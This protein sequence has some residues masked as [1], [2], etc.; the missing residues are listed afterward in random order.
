[1]RKLLLLVLL[2]AAV[3]F[4]LYTHSAA[5]EIRRTFGEVERLVSRA[6]TE[7]VMENAVKSRM[8]STYVIEGCVFGLK[9][10]GV[11]GRTSREGFSGGVLAFRNEVKRIRLRFIDL[12]IE[13][14]DRM[15]HV[16]GKADFTGTDTNGRLVEP[17]IRAFSAD[18]RREDDGR[19]RFMCVR[20]D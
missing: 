4:W 18:L 19:W 1:M 3:A 10:F 9:E 20:M 12:Q 16:E 5:A 6:E 11:S 2:L 17:L 7:S 13:S 15:A 14:A 8:L